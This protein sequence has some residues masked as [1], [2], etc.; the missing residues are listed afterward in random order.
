MRSKQG[1]VLSRRKYL[2]DLLNET[3][4]MG[5][6]SCSAS[7]PSNLQI[8]KDRDPFEDRNRYRRLV[9]KLNYLV[10]LRS[11][12]AYLVSVVN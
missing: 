4:K 3:R 7:M 12:I 1:V 10:I 2:L 9:E 8:T 11:N 6:K 5:A